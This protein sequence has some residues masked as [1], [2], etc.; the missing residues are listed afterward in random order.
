MNLFLGNDREAAESLVKRFHYTG[1]VPANVQ[2]VA[3]WHTPGGLFGDAGE[4]IAAAIF[5]IP[6]SRWNADVWELGWLVRHEG[7]CPP[8]SRFLGEVV[9]EMRRLRTCPL[10]VSFA[11]VQ[12]GHHGG[13]YRA[14][15][16]TTYG[17]RSPRLEGLTVNGAFVPGRVCNHRYGTQSP[18]ELRRRRPELVV[19]PKFDQ[20][21][22]LYWKALNRW[23]VTR[24]KALGLCGSGLNG[25]PPEE[26][27]GKARSDSGE[28]L[29]LDLDAA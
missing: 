16:W 29:S 19:E 23:G 7:A 11:D 2:F 24:A 13:I 25:E 20:G 5:T 12:Q 26:P 17:K 27:I 21:K 9:R 18:D 6:A 1:R 14:A 4:A 3:T 22:W 15:G 8:L 28:P 10:L